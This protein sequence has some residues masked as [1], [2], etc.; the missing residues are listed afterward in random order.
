[1]KLVTYV[2][3]DAPSRLEGR[4]G[5][6]LGDLV[7]DLATLG[8]WAAHHGASL[9][10]TPGQ[11]VLP[12]TMLKLLQRGAEG[13]DAARAALSLAEKARPEDLHEEAALAH[14]MSA[15]ALRSPVPNPPTLRDF[16][17]FE[18]HVKA[19]RARRKA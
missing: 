8:E 3:V 11:R 17:A 4:A 15:V 14:A 16:Y 10:S 12:Q 7:L 9:P 19:A 6:L 13:M 18:Q 5:V 2:P 1:M